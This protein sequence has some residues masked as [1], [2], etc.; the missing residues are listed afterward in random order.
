MKT[1]TSQVKL[2]KTLYDKLVARKHPGR[3][4]QGLFRKCSTGLRRRKVN[5]VIR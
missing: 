4:L 3:P 1:E 2:P 5:N